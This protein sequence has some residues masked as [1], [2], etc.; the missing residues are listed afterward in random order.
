MSVVTLGVPLLIGTARAG[1]AYSSAI[2]ENVG[3]SGGSNFHIT[4]SGKLVITADPKVTGAAMIS[5]LSLKGVECGAALDD[6]GKTGKCG[7]A[8]GLGEDAVLEMS[9]HVLGQ[10]LPATIGLPL[11][12]IKGTAYFVSPSGNT[13]VMDGTS[14]GGLISLILGQPMGFGVSKIRD[15]AHG[16]VLADCATVPPAVGSKCLNGNEWAFT[17][18]VLSN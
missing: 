14:F 12:I 16:T 13:A 15:T 1:D 18:I 4:K 5:K 9:V 10:D 11:K 3:F 7:V 17:G 2:V 6:K 8:A